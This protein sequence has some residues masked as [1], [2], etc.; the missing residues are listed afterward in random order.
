MSVQE[1]WEVVPDL[2][3]EARLDGRVFVQEVDCP[4]QRL[5]GCFVP[6][7][8]EGH[9][10]IHQVL[11][12]ELFGPESDADDIGLLSFSGRQSIFR[13]L[14]RLLAE[15]SDRIVGLCYFLVPL[16]RNSLEYA[17]GQDGP[18]KRSPARLSPGPE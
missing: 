13:S 7:N 3:A 15:M 18:Q 5:G 17:P 4:R 8:E 2:G 16:E 9:H 10:L 12:V 1:R 6:G 11:V 14:N